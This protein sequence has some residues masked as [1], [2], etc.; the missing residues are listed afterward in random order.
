MSTVQEIEAAIPRLS[1]A[2]IEEIRAWI[3][4]FLE[5]RLEL[6]DEVKAKLDQSRSEIAAGHYTTRQPK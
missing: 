3:D 1:R 2:E 4:D 6:T 5:D